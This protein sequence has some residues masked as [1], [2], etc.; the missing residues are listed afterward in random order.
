LIKDPL[1]H[2]YWITLD[3]SDERTQVFPLGYG[4]TAYTAEDAFML[5][6]IELFGGEPLPKIARVIEDVDLSAL[7]ARHVLPNCG[8]PV[9]RGVWF[10]NIGRPVDRR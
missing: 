3:P 8:E 5:L 9:R 2:R 1:L 4:V 6:R 10:P 7:D